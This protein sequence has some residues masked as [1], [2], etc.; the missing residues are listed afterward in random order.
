[1]LH[2]LL[3]LLSLLCLFLRIKNDSRQNF[4]N[5]VLNK[6]ERKK[7]TEARIN[8]LIEFCLPK[9]YKY[10]SNLD[11]S[12]WCGICTSIIN[13][14]PQLEFSILN[15]HRHCLMFQ[16]WNRCGWLL[17]YW[18]QLLNNTIL[19]AANYIYNY[20]KSVI[21]SMFIFTKVYFTS[22]KPTKYFDFKCIFSS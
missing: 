21:N 3:N 4:M 2:F 14:N 8:Y 11:T 5:V 6:N 15:S 13:R 17:Y 22:D 18:I 7:P 9:K 20:F 12:H 1:M 10:K 19:S 16:S